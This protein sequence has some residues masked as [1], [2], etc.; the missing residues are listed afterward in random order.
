MTDEPT[1]YELLDGTSAEKNLA[2]DLAG[3]IDHLSRVLSGVEDGNWRYANDRADDLRDSIARFQRRLTDTIPD[4]HGDVQRDE[5]GLAIRRFAPPEANGERVT[6]AVTAFVQDYAAG[7][8]LFPLDN[9]TG[10]VKDRLVK[11]LKRNAEIQAALDNGD[12]AALS[13]LTGR[14]VTISGP[15]VTLTDP[16]DT[17]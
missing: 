4:G 2:E 12:A 10:P 17:Q 1:V 11:D 14:Q 3:V 16:G 9:L 8:A 6:Q 13:R 5:D 15:Q 7:R